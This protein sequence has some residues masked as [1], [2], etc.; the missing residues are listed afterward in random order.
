MFVYGILLIPHTEKR[1]K[2]AILFYDNVKFQKNNLVVGF[3]FV[4]QKFLL[5]F[6][7][8]CRGNLFLMCKDNLYA[9]HIGG[10]CLNA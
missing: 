3:S 8:N 4:I 2:L 5:I 9:H 1:I 6:L 10:S 7:M